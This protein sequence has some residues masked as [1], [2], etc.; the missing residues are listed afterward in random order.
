MYLFNSAEKEKKEKFIFKTHKQKMKRKE[1][2]KK[3][4]TKTENKLK[5]SASMK[6]C[7]QR[8]C[9]RCGLGQRTISKDSNTNI[10]CRRSTIM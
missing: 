3:K 8:P 4:K 7:K 2:E 1:K 5:L 6:A 10:N 9:D